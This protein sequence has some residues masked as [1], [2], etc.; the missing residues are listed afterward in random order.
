MSKTQLKA[1]ALNAAPKMSEEEQKS[2]LK[3]MLMAK[4][5]AV[6]QMCL[7]SLCQNQSAV[8]G[9]PLVERAFQMAEDFVRRAYG[10]RVEFVEESDET[11]RE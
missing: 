5:E 10:Y 6:A 2:Q 3:R 4:R 7:S 9:E 1:G 11:P 8:I